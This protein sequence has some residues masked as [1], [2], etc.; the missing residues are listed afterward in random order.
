MP[1]SYFMVF[2][3][4][5]TEF[6]SSCQESDLSLC[7]MAPSIFKIF[8]TSLL[9]EDRGSYL[10]GMIWESQEMMHINSINRA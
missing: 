7:N 2:P 1:F 9:N 8:S 4:R 5:K 3:P 10:K 6:V